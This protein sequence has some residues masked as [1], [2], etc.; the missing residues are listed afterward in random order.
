M[1]TG[2][3]KKTNFPGV[4][5]REHPTKKHG[6]KFDRYF[7]IR[8]QVTKELDEID[9]ETGK[10]KKIKER[11]EE[12]IGWT[13]ERDPEDGQNWTESKAALV[14]ERL[15]GA[16]K[17]G[18]KEAPTRIAEQREIERQRKEAEK[19][20]QE[21]AEQERKQAEAESVTFGHYFEN[22]YFPT[23]QVGRKKETTRKAKEHF[24]NWLE[25]VI[26]NIP[27]K[28]VKPFTLEKIKKNIL[29]A[30]KSPRTLQYV[31]ATFRQVW[32]MARRDGLIS[33]DTPT[34]SI[35][36]PK[37]DNR[38]VRFLSHKEAET[39]LNALQ[40]KDPLT[41]DL[42]L[43]SLHTGLRMGEISGLNW[44]H[45]DTERGIIRVMNPKGGE[46]RA[47]FMTTQIKAVFE[48]MTRR[49]PESFLFTRTDGK[50]LK[51]MPRI[52]FEV[53]A[54]LKLNEGITDPRQ[55]VVA[56]TLRHTF[57]SWHVTAG[58]DIYTLEELLGHSVIAMTER[59]SHLAPATLQ[60]ATRG[61]ERAIESAEQEKAKDQAGQVVNLK[62]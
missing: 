45:I 44:S 59:Y 56:H 9:P 34:R 25:P 15:K 24:K 62:K 36:K 61:F 47:A 42:A 4:R 17:H 6:V 35:N 27:L 43:L 48:A 3:W 58:T 29:D 21:Q 51:E 11:I 60:N 33:G 38:R 23:F 7:T 26:G 30:G 1:T 55:K 18:K 5:F 2:K 50:P 10:K 54:G 16:A 49:E 12:G 46:G 57:A 53:V 8:Y 39:L 14:L 19:A 40:E 41:H 31:M 37:V 22:V 52:F 20:A 28:D 32:N 13:S